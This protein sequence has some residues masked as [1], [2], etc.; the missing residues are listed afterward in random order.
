VLENVLFQGLG[1]DRVIL[2][3]VGPAAGNKIG[4]YMK[5]AANQIDGVQKP[6][7]EGGLELRIPDPFLF[8]LLPNI[9]LDLFLRKAS[10]VMG[11]DA[12]GLGIGK[13]F[14]VVFSDVKNGI[15]PA[16]ALQGKSFY[17]LL[18]GKEVP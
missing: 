13:I 8:Q 11:V 14:G 2:G 17:E 15:G 5:A 10:Q 9:R 7:A 18:F 6:T 12:N 4:R 16:D 3:K 1:L